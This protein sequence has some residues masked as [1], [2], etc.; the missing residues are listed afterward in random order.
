MYM[1]VYMSEND[2]LTGL[3]TI[4]TFHEQLQSIARAGSNLVL[5]VLD[6]DHLLSINEMYGHQAGD[7][8]IRA[9]AQHFQR[10]FGGEASLV[11]RSGGDDFMAVIQ[12]GDL[13]DIF[14]RAEELRQQ[15]EST[16]LEFNASGET[17]YLSNTISLGLAA[18]PA[19]AGDPDDLIE[20]GKQA[21]YRAKVAGGNRVCFYQ[22]TDTLTGLLNKH[23]SQ[24]TLEEALRK[25]RQA[26]EP[27]SVFLLDIDRF[28]EINTDYGHRA[29]DEILIRLAHVLERNFKD[30]GVVG[31][32]G[33][34]EFL[35]ILPGQRADSAFILAEEVRRLV[36]DSE[37]AAAV[38]VHNYTLRY[39]ISGG[40]AT[41]PGDATERV[42]LLRKADEALYR[43]KRI[44]RNRISLPASAQMVTKTSHYTLIQL[45]RLAELAHK[46]ERT[47]AFLLREALDD[48]LRKY[49][50]P[51]G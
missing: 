43:S 1:E 4:K 26:G 30:V 13:G 38:G 15:V 40:I 6:L 9:N 44:G 27:L 11:G 32:T 16:R 3:L 2:E 28:N 41:F 50:D 14:E 8:W 5:V 10:V 35:V 34:D 33:G 24:R 20:K 49:G 42:D 12:N 31:R 21:L 29:G 36:E 7:E 23:A 17:I 51:V 48:L 37:I 39:R 22:E 25:A 47:E 46:Q 45:E 19:N 18:F